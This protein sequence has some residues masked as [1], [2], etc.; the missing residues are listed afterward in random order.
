MLTN[1]LNIVYS[2]EFIDSGQVVCAKFLLKYGQRAQPMSEILIVEDK[3]V[4]IWSYEEG[5]LQQ[6]NCLAIHKEVRAAEYLELSKEIVLALED[7]LFITLD[8][9]VPLSFLTLLV[10]S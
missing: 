5:R 2:N 6:C 8:P 4:T 9:Q 7:N 10:Q 1:Q 3:A